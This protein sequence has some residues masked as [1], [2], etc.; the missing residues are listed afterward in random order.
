MNTFIVGGTGFIGY[1][2][3]LEFLKRGHNVFTL[4]LPDIKPGPWFP[5]EIVINYGNI[6][7][8]T[9]KQLINLFKGQEALVYAI[10]PDDRVTPEPPAYKFFH[11]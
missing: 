5:Q 6:F 3:A 8:M 10:G 7:E 2:S 9:E 4:S 11:E 1:H